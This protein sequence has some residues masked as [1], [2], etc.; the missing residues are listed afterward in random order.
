WKVVMHSTAAAAATIA[1][2]AQVKQ[3]IIGHFS[4]RVLD[5]TLF[6]EEA[7]PIFE[8]TILAEERKTY[9]LNAPL[10]TV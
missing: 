7:K 5:Q 10:M 1:Q 4:A 9:V 6:L 3:L 2:K 8:N